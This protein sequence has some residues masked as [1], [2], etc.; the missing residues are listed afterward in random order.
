MGHSYV[1]AENRRL[2]HEMALAGGGR[3]Q[4]TAIAPSHLRGDLRRI[5]LEP[6]P[7]EACAVVPLEMAFDRS[8]HLMWFRGLRRALSAGADVVHAWEEP[9]VH[10]GMQIA[11]SSPPSA[12]V[13]FAT[14]QNIS[15]HYPWPFSAFERA[16]I[17]RASG[18]IAFGHRVV[19]ALGDREG[20]DGK[21]MRVIPPGVDVER[22]RP[23]PEAGAAIRAQIGW[24]DHAL[25]VGYLGRFEPQKG[26]TD[27][28]AA[29]ERA[30]APW[31]AL[32][33][34][35]GS[36]QRDIEA[37]GA[38]HP[39]RVHVAGGVPHSDVPRWL[40]AMT[41]LCAPSRTTAAW[42]EQFGRMLIE[43][44]ACGVPTLVSDS[45]EMPAVVHDAG[46]VLPERDPVPWAT[47]IDNHL[48][49][50]RTLAALSKRG[51][52]RARAYFA[53]PVVAKRHL[54]FFDALVDGRAT[55]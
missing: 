4:V 32:F 15:K 46:R 39:G 43:A 44:M 23:D 37:F 28:I 50:A 7:H 6:I 55:P 8:A 14:F 1:V 18:W 35:G 22:F 36:L 10:A 3:W 38:A 11:R 2:A 26:V 53:W 48:R 33:V 47:S 42:R 31:H 29:L 54:D 19:D 16:S 9:Y 21:P 5:D 24:S 12:R 25:V 34:G 27:L 40:N 45:G 30:R 49:D 52:E 51:V 41:I 17:R 20:Y 13:V